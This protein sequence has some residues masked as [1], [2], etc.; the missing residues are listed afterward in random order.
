MSDKRQEKDERPSCIVCPVTRN[1]GDKSGGV[2]LLL[3]EIAQVRKSTSPGKDQDG[4]DEDHGGE[5]SE[6]R[7]LSRIGTV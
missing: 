5:L 6:H 4:D 2:V 7:D 3:L 1:P